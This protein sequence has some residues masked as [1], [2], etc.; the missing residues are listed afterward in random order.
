MSFRSLSFNSFLSQIVGFSF[1]FL[2]V[3]LLV[4]IL[5]KSEFGIFQQ[6]NLIQTTVI[7]LFGFTL[8]SSLYY[9]NSISE[10]K[11]EKSYYINQTYIILIFSSLL[12]LTSAFLLKKQILDLLNINALEEVSYIVSF[13]ITLYLASSIC[14]NIFLL[15][16]NNV[17]ILYFLPLE[18]VA[19]LTFV[20][21]SFL[22]KENFYNI[23]FGIFFV[24][25]LKFSFATYYLV[26]VHSLFEFK[27]D[28]VKV[29]KQ[30]NYCWPF[31]L[32]TI[33]YIFSSKID[34]YLLTG[35][36]SPSDYAIYSVSFLSIPFL[37]N[38]YNSVNN[39]VI[40][41]FTALIKN[42]SIEELK[43]LYKNVVSKTGSISIPFLFFFFSFSQFFVELVFTKAYSEG[44]LYYK[45][46]LLSFLSMFT[47][48][49]LILRASNKTKIIFIINMISALVTIIVASI[50]VPKYLLLGAAITSV[51]AVL[52]PSFLQ[53]YFEI[54]FIKSRFLDFFPWE[55]AIKI[56]GISI[57][58]FPIRIFVEMV[59]SS[60]NVV[61][62][63]SGIIYFPVSFFI[64]FLLKLLPFRDYIK[65]LRRK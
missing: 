2:S 26:K 41:E 18:K 34:K 50:I 46:G 23:F 5:E 33:V 20:I 52:L 32:G 51:I 60:I 22:Y 62:I 12:F 3:F 40:P 59:F 21:S 48:Y 28:I 45:I 65:F 25:L 13:S 63:A 47:S 24:S 14:D 53:L 29:K 15:D 39:V 16:K 6:F 36:V 42:G 30:L 54:K 27:F 61:A 37:A 35:I 56:I 64:L 49:G 31:Y 7:P 55:E 1:H 8:V 38:A 11:K 57:L 58:I 17:G 4:R 19:F 44:V 9:F 10:E 43:N